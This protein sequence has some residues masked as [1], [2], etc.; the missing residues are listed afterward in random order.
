MNTNLMSRLSDRLF[1]E[2][3]FVLSC[4][5]VLGFCAPVVAVLVIAEIPA[6]APAAGSR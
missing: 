6:A 5:L 3:S 2:W 4:L 1:P